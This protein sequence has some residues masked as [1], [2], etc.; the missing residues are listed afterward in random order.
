MTMAP[1][2][3]RNSI[4][5]HIARLAEKGATLIQKEAREKALTE[6]R[7]VEQSEVTALTA[8]ESEF[9]GPLSQL[10]TLDW[11]VLGRSVNV[12][13]S[14]AETKGILSDL[15]DAIKLHQDILAI[16]AAGNEPT[17]AV[18][19]RAIATRGLADKLRVRMQALAESVS[20]L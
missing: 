20:K 2:E 12:G 10:L 4:T 19:E 1:A 14:E 11:P 5:G 15:A 8:F 7:R 16:F 3:L 13:G 6:L 9:G 18:V 17:D